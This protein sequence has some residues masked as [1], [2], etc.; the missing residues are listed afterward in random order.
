MLIVHYHAYIEYSAIMATS[1]TRTELFGLVTMK[2][3]CRYF[4]SAELPNKMD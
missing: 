4:S 3:E 1:R 2:I